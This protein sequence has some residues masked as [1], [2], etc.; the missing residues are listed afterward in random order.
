MIEYYPLYLPIEI[1]IAL[2]LVLTA[3]IIILWL[4]TKDD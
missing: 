1:V 2:G 3:L 4:C